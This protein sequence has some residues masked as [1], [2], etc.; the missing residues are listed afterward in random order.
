MTKEIRIV[1]KEG[2]KHPKNNCQLKDH[3][4]ASFQISLAIISLKKYIINRAKLRDEFH[5]VLPL[6]D[7]HH[8]DTRHTCEEVRWR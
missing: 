2:D 6:D 7:S 4:T 3:K 5:R 8:D 1:T